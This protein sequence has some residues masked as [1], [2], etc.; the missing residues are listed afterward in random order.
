MQA[1]L[2]KQINSC[3]EAMTSCAQHRQH[4]A[5]LP[6]T[7]RAAVSTTKE[8]S[9]SNTGKDQS[10]LFSNLMSCESL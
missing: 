10:A 7:A 4:D 3:R 6:C 1:L 9:A 2:T 5:H 8:A